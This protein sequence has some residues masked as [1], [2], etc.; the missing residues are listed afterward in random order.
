MGNR[1][2]VSA[3]TNAKS[4]AY[5]MRRQGLGLASTAKNLDNMNSAK[6]LKAMLKRGEDPKSAEPTA[7]SSSASGDKG[8]NGEGRS[9]D[10]RARLKRKH[11]DDDSDDE[12]P[13]EVRS[14]E[15]KNNNGQR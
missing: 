3:V 2:P 8:G 11:N 4:E 12:P 15:E 13:D 14:Q 1:G 7:S 6:A 5:N 10:A 9:E